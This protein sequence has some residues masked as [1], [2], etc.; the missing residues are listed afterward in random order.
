[1]SKMRPDFH[2]VLG[3]SPTFFSQLARVG[4]V[5]PEVHPLPESLRQIDPSAKAHVHPSQCSNSTER[6]AR[7]ASLVC[8]LCKN[9]RQ[10]GNPAASRGRGPPPGQ[11]VLSVRVRNQ[12]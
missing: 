4:H 12:D 9:L 10:P 8:H 3:I 1:M 2:L 6:M 5:P 7:T 11:D